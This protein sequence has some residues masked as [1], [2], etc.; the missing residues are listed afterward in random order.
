MFRHRSVANSSPPNLFHQ[1]KRT[2]THLS[3]LNQVYFVTKQVPQHIYMKP[4][5]S[6]LPIIHQSPSVVHDKPQFMS[7]A[8]LSSVIDMDTLNISNKYFT[9]VLAPKRSAQSKAAALRGHSHTFKSSVVN[10]AKRPNENLMIK[11]SKPNSPSGQSMNMLQSK[12]EIKMGSRSTPVYQ[13]REKTARTAHSR[14]LTY[15]TFD[16]NKKV[17]VG[18]VNQRLDS[19][20]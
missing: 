19:Y 7:S 16:E 6:Y 4:Q 18:I 11:N 17:I 1:P 15:F 2:D 5:L 12:S 13:R 8:L 14:A 3:K 9:T 20:D 10:V